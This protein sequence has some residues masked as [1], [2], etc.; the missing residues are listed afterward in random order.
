MKNIILISLIFILYSCESY[1]DKPKILGSSYHWINYHSTIKDIKIGE[2]NIKQINI[3][4]LI[5]KDT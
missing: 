3:R 5:D 1:V 4:L 2:L